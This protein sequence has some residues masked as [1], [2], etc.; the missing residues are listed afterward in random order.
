MQQANSIRSR[1]E[2]SQAASSVRSATAEFFNWWGREL[3]SCVP[4][5]L[6]K[7]L[8]RQSAQIAFDGENISVTLPIRRVE[9]RTL[10][11]SLQNLPGLAQQIAESATWIGIDRNAI[12]AVPVSSFLR[13]ELILPMAVR[14]RLAQAVQYQIGRFSPFPEADTQHLTRVL[15]ARPQSKEL[16]AEV[17]IVQKRELERLQQV[18][19]AL[20]L[21]VG[22][23]VFHG[24]SEAPGAVPLSLFPEGAQTRKRF[25]PL[26][27]CLVIST[28]ALASA[29]AGT[30]YAHRINLNDRLAA[31]IDVLK[32]EAIKVAS[33]KEALEEQAATAAGIF[34]AKRKMPQQIAILD[35]LASRLPD[36]VRLTEYRAAESGVQITGYARDAS[37]LL[38][39]IDATD[40]FRSARFA[41][42]VARDQQSGLDRFSMSFELMERP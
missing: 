17:V 14:P 34:S 25:A 37:R 40:G 12:V 27:V 41:A 5:R 28:L 18:V 3:R 11:G 32:P 6:R 23:F 38:A 15:S 24:E 16:V 8:A 39:V 22:R 29:A 1:F 2:I 35:Q 4:E 20:G 30:L 19:Q 10:T 26:D 9:T 33:L 7:S 31:E 36:D 13:R 42:P 21:T